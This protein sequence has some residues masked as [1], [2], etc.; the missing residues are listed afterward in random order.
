MPQDSETTTSESDQEWI[1]FV[2]KLKG[3]MEKLQLGVKLYLSLFDR[4]LQN[5][6]SRMVIFLRNFDAKTSNIDD[7]MQGLPPEATMNVIRAVTTRC[8][9]FFAP[10][11]PLTPKFDNFLNCISEY[12]RRVGYRQQEVVSP[13]S[14]YKQK[15]SSLQQEDV[16]TKKETNSNCWRFILRAYSAISAAF[17]KVLMVGS[18][19]FNALTKGADT[20]K[21]AQDKSDHGVSEDDDEDPTR[22]YVPRF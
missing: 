14:E 7:L 11:I 16:S 8:D 20:S 18:A 12:K 19:I 9:E 3:L 22:F 17:F 4:N 10:S 2:V 1:D 15:I 21:S 13:E 5:Q 6:F